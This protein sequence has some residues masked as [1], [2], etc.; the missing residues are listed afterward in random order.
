MAQMLKWA[1]NF[2]SNLVIIKLTNSLSKSSSCY[3]LILIN[4]NDI[5]FN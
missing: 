4:L 3:Y 1:Q 2:A 5:Y